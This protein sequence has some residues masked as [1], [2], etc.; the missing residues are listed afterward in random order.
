MNQQQTQHITIVTNMQ[1]FD[2][3]HND[4]EWTQVIAAC[5]ALSTLLPLPPVAKQTVEDWM[6]HRIAYTATQP[7]HRL[8]TVA[9]RE[10]LRVFTH[11]TDPCHCSPSIT[12]KMCADHEA[13]KLYFRNQ[14]L[15]MP[16]QVMLEFAYEA[17][18]AAARRIARRGVRLPAANSPA[19]TSDATQ[20]GSAQTFTLVPAGLA[21]DKLLAIFCGFRNGQ[22][23][24]NANAWLR[25]KMVR[26]FRDATLGGGGHHVLEVCWPEESERGKVATGAVEDCMDGWIL[27]RNKVQRK[28]PTA[29]G[30]ESGSEAGEKENGETEEGEMSESEEAEVGESSGEGESEAD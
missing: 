14:Q 2:N 1:I 26:T 29:D 17:Q 3:L 30:E 13:V 12:K 10:I 25:E 20:T 4:Q 9:Q 6:H 18:V 15:A 28:G 7:H 21:S 22:L 16:L 19:T 11:I 27:A 8:L 24:G 23:S 5:Q